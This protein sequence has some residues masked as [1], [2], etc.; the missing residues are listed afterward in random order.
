M[1]NTSVVT[2]TPRASFMQK[3]LHT[4]HTS[5]PCPENSC[6]NNG[7]LRTGTRG[8]S[9]IQSC[10][11]RGQD[12][13]ALETIAVDPVQLQLSFSWDSYFIYTWQSGWQ[14]VPLVLY[15]TPGSPFSH[16]LRLLVVSR[17][18]EGRQEGLDRGLT[19]NRS[20]RGSCFATYET[21]T[22]NPWVIQQRAPHKR[23]QERGRP[24]CGRAPAQS[25]GALL[26][27]FDIMGC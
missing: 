13:E 1:G 26:T 27:V 11:A 21:L 6:W 24:S 15:V 8:E 18:Q 7:G 19:F 17:T 4:G 20:Q 12:P 16:C 14:P 10:P 22:Y 25:Q 2:N 5:I 23:N 3:T 9:S